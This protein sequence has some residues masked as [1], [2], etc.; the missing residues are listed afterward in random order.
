[1]R[2]HDASIIAYIEHIH[3][4]HSVAIKLSSGPKENS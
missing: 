4:I 3:R 1:M 2:R